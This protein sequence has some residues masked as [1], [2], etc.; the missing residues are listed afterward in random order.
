MYVF[1]GLRFE[2]QGSFDI[3]ITIL[4]TH[5]FPIIY[6]HLLSTKPRMSPRIRDKEFIRRG[7]E[8]E[9]EDYDDADYEDEEY[10]DVGQDYET[11]NREESDAGN[12]AHGKNDNDANDHE[13][14]DDEE[15]NQSA[16]DRKYDKLPQY[17]TEEMKK[18]HPG[19]FPGAGAT[20]GQIASREER[21]NDMA[22]S[23]RT[24][25][26]QEQHDRSTSGNHYAAVARDAEGVVGEDF[27]FPA[28]HPRRH[29][30]KFD[31]SD[32]ED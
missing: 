9:N 29:S 15:D 30:S 28:G 18:R 7:T 14:S 8:G 21:R 17:T 27:A 6:Q 13:E 4:L 31:A 10:H 1:C 26:M 12:N 16:A 11:S 24:P 22:E 2:A 19:L 32:D 23:S 5:S 25:R 3:S 20:A